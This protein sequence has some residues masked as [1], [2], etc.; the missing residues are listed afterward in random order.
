MSG[1]SDNRLTLVP[2]VGLYASTVDDSWMVGKVG[3]AASNITCAPLVGDGQRSLGEWRA[4]DTE[5]HVVCDRDD[6][7]PRSGVESEYGLVCV[8]VGRHRML[9]TETA[10]LGAV[11]GR[12]AWGA[13]GGKKAG[14]LLVW[15]W[16]LADIDQIEV[17]R[18]KKALK[19]WDVGLII[20]CADP[21]AGLYYSAMG[22]GAAPFGAVD[23]T[24][25]AAS[26]EGSAL[27]GFAGAIAAAA[28]AGGRRVERTQ[29][30][31]RKGLVSVFRFSPA[32]G[33][34]GPDP[35]SP[36]GALVSGGPVAGVAATV[37]AGE[38]G[39][40]D[41]LDA[42]ADSPPADAPVTS[43]APDPTAEK[44]CTQCGT[45]LSEQW[46]FCRACGAS[47]TEPADTHPTPGGDD[48][49]REGSVSP[50]GP[51]PAPKNPTSP[52]TSRPAVPRQPKPTAIPDPTDPPDRQDHGK[53]RQ[54]IAAAIAVVVVAAGFAWWATTNTGDE[55]GTTSV[56]GGE[57]TDTIPVGAG[58]SVVAVGEGA[59][60]V[61][62]DGSVSR[63]D[64]ASR[65]VTDTIPAGTGLTGMAVSEGAGWV[66]YG[67]DGSVLRID[68][69]SREVTDTIPVGARLTGLAVGEGAVWVLSI[70]D[71]FDGSVLRIDPASGEVSETIFVDPMPGEV[72]VGEGAVWV[73]GGD[74]GGD[75]SVLRIDPASGEVTETIPIGVSFPGDVAVGEG[76]VWVGGD[77][78]VLRI[79]PASG[80]VTDTIPVGAGPYGVAVGEGAVW[81]GGDGSVLRIDPAS[82][83]VTDT[84]PVGAGGAELA[85]GEGAV[86]VAN[87]DEGT[88][89][90]I[91]P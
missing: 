66:M 53:H 43:A 80:E 71:N 19:L 10:L 69:A 84:I 23:K 63:I 12:T 90:R 31:D 79:D 50:T 7:G 30:Q 51:A 83:E 26:V 68:L 41:G 15:K 32:A 54:V 36:G 60:W 22:D 16:D 77:G 76:A 75:G 61:G 87:H 88:V 3:V 34:A 74:A 39:G 28:T 91:E 49:A 29:R 45:P 52:P 85:V 59:I 44:F 73:V 35:G 65:E 64:P 24:A 48:D 1:L 38:G 89:S 21:E 86:W 25:K 2:A 33:G 82:G 72:A 18:L 81:V 8:A 5:L 6:R 67:F 46:Q 42:P 27:L 47:T 62:G 57:V 11:E 40:P 58:P 9:L 37:L 17:H 70:D 4:S 56:G 20:T 13:S 78:S 55:A 14:C